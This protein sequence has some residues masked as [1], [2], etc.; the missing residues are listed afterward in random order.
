VSGYIGVVF[1]F[2]HVATLRWGW[3]FLIPGGTKWEA[4]YA[5]S[6]LAMV[7]QGGAEGMTTAGLIVSIFYMAGV[8]LLVFHLANGLWSAAITWGLTV[9]QKAQD[10]WGWVCAAIGVA[11]MA[12]A[13]SA[14]IGFATLDPAHAEAAE[15]M[16]NHGHPE[17]A[18]FSAPDASVSQVEKGE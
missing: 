4:E 13:W 2:Y 8:S 5:A 11:L 18:E 10:R 15:R 9:T 16:V 14:V 1:I 3:T 17:S 12:M 7:F 6:R